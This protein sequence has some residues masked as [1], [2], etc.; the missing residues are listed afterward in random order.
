MGVGT[1]S[2]LHLVV[3]KVMDEPLH[4]G[5]RVGL[6]E[7]FVLSRS[8]ELDVL[9]WRDGQLQILTRKINA[10]D[11]E[12]DDYFIITEGMEYVDEDLRGLGSGLAHHLRFDGPGEGLAIR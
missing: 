2:F 11:A 7:Q 9:L 6:R 12:D 4:S 10:S 5:Q 8:H 1:D 3:M